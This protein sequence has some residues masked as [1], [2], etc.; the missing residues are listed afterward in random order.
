MTL[1][2]SS[3]WW[4]R[5]RGSAETVAALEAERTERLKQWCES[6]VRSYRR[7]FPMPTEYKGPAAPA[8][9]RRKARGRGYESAKVRLVWML[10]D[11]CAYCGEAADTWDHIVPRKAG[12]DHGDDNLCRVCFPCNAE[13]TS[14]ALLMFLTLR[15]QRKADGTWTRRGDLQL[16]GGGKR[17]QHK[18]N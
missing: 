9:K 7:G 2:Y 8:K 15:A 14:R 6:T 17:N 16:Q 11:P 10:S 1:G 4:V 18:E 12:G 3:G 5:I 13:K